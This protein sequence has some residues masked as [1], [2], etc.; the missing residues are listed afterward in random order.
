[1]AKR[2]RKREG[3]KEGEGEWS[4]EIRKNARRI[5]ESAY[6]E[7]KVALLLFLCP[8]FL[9][10]ALFSVTKLPEGVPPSWTA[11]NFIAA[12][13]SSVACRARRRPEEALFIFSIHRLLQKYS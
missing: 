6:R 4:S 12:S 5:G 3:G 11:L 7:N 1:M 13:W 2:K 10:H 9:L 8:R